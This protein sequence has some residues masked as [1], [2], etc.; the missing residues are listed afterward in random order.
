MTK[1]QAEAGPIYETLGSEYKDGTIA[2]RRISTGV[3]SI[4]V[5]EF[6]RLANADA[7][8]GERPRA[9]GDYGP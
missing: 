4:G 1:E 8:Y 6:A 5:T 2:F 9:S 7:A 3:I